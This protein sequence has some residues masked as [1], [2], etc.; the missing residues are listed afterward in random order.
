MFLGKPEKKSRGGFCKIEVFDIANGITSFPDIT[1][2]KLGFPP[3][4]TPGFDW[5]EI[6]FQ[7]WSVKVD[8]DRIESNGADIYRFSLSGAI[9]LD[10]AERFHILHDAQRK[11]Y[12]IRATDLNGIVKI[13]GNPE[14]PVSIITQKRDTGSKFQDGTKMDVS[15]SSTNRHPFPEA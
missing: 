12:I 10:S 6:V 8:E 3:Q 4:F 13:I 9:H 7:R 11:E 2:L 14:E 5:E 15:I 1:N